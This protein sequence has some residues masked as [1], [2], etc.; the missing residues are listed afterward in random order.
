[1]ALAS[2]VEEGPKCSEDSIEPLRF[3]H[4]FPAF[5]PD[6]KGI[7]HLAADGG[8]PGCADVEAFTS[9]AVGQPV[10]EADLVGSSNFH[11]GGVGG[12]LIVRQD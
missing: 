4:L 12:R 11:N 7:N 5:G 9:E 3:G 6:V 1:M 10:Q 8:H 2:G